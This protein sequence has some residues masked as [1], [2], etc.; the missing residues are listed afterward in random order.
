MKQITKH[1]LFCLILLYEIGSTTLF[2]LGGSAKQDSWIVVFLAMLIGFILLWVYTEITKHFP[3][4]HLAEI[5][6]ILFGKWIAKPL[7]FFYAGHLFYDAC[8]NFFEFGEI[9]RITSLMNTPPFI[10]GG[11]FIVTVIY[12][13]LIGQWV[14]SR[15][16]EILLP[17]F[18]FFLLI[19]LVFSVVSR[20]FDITQLQ[21]I[22]GN[23]M[24][25]ILKALPGVII[26][27]FGEMVVFLF[28]W[29]FVDEKGSVRF[30]SFLSFSLA[31]IIII[32]SQ[33]I[34]ISV[35][36]P[37][38]ATNAEVPLLEVILSINLG[39]IIM[40]LDVLLIIMLFIGGLFKMI[41]NFY[42]S[43]LALLY[44][45][46]VKEQKFMIILIGVCIIGYSF[47]H[48]KTLPHQR[49]ITDAAL[50]PGAIWP[51]SEMIYQIIPIYIL[52]I[53]ILNKKITN[54]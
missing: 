26:F 25:P 12:M 51:W 18:L 50:W 48:L 5:I 17:V 22:M 2:L 1:Q 20:H 29:K 38:L 27:P 23:G 24:T 31:G 43:V 21:P 15:T 11:V 49:A 3:E 7:I 16:S 9:M 39:D 28:L 14:V 54:K 13:L 34:I 10:I 42:G 41:I 52:I 40:N 19:S 46:N 32:L 33:I 53:I 35:L 6:S 30:I 36:G 37:G 4:D 47:I 44:L 8:L 45:F